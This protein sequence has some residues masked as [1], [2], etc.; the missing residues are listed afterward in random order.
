LLAGGA[1][2]E[3]EHKLSLNKI[4]CGRTPGWPAYHIT[5][6]PVNATTECTDLLQSVIRYW[7]VL[8]GTSPE[9]LQE[10]FLQREGKLV[11]KEEGWR[12]WVEYKT[13][14]ILLQQMPW[15]FSVVKFPWMQYPLYIEW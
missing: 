11:F 12:L 4:L 1:W 6:M 15:S 10:T 9:G 13:P 14:D 3:A 7:D 2:D 5:G 8:K